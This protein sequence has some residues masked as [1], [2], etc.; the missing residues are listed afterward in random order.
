M[1]TLLLSVLLLF[2][3]LSS[4]H[5]QQTVTFKGGILSTKALWPHGGDWVM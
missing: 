1:K 3:V 2:T 4:A 5:A